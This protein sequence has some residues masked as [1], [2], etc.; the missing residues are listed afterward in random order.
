MKRCGAISRREGGVLESGV[1]V[2]HVQ[3]LDRQRGRVVV[4]HLEQREWESVG[5]AALARGK[6]MQGR[7][8]TRWALSV[9]SELC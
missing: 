2:Q 5:P 1:M 4:H 7:W 6:S 8:R 3:G 9:A